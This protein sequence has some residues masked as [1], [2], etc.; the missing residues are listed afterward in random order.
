[1]YIWVYV[2]MGIV[3]RLKQFKHT[4]NLIAKNRK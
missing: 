3:F 2:Y 4:T 1:M